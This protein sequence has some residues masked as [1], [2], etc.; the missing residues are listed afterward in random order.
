MADLSSWDATSLKREIKRIVS[1]I[2]R[3][4][5]SELEDHLK[6]RDELGIDSL[7]AMEILGTC[8]KRLRLSLDEKLFADVQTVGD[9]LDL[10][11]AAWSRQIA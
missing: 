4:D 5:A 2:S 11:V 6:I 7:M 1:G 10:M 9:F 8:E 3:I